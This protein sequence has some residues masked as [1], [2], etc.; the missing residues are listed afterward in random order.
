MLRLTQ[1]L[2]HSSHGPDPS[3]FHSSIEIVSHS[4]VLHKIKVEVIYK[5]NLTKN[6]AFNDHIKVHGQILV[7]FPKYEMS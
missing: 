6:V 5:N 1:R 3:S 7:K 2:S 4:T